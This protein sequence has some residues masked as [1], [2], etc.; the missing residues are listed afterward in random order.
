MKN[1]FSQDETGALIKRINQLSPSSQRNWGKM[2]ASQM[3]AHCNVV[4]ELAYENIHPQNNFFMRLLLKYLVKNMVVNDK[5]YKQNLQTASVFIMASEKDFSKEKD[6]LI[7][8]I[9]KTLE[10]GRDY[11]ENKDS[12]SFGIL[13]SQEWN[14]MFYKHLD[15]HLSQF[16]C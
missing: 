13:T 6:R 2:D 16:N 9:N 14:N 3:L 4:Y 15:H 11:F 1:I 7:I 12:H 8:Y 10:H 5:P